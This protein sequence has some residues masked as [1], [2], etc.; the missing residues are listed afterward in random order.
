MSSINSCLNLTVTFSVFF[1]HYSFLYPFPW[2]WYLFYW[3]FLFFFPQK[4]LWVAKFPILC[5]SKVFILSPYLNAGLTRHGI[6]VQNNIGL[7]SSVQCY[8]WE[9]NGEFNP[10]VFVSNPLFCLCNPLGFFFMMLWHS[11]MMIKVIGRLKRVLWH[12]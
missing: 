11:R 12:K 5:R 9:I 7:F 8:C 4:Y 10:H 3:I 6:W 1:D 2:F